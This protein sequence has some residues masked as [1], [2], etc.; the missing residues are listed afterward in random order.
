MSELWSAVVLTDKRCDDCGLRC[1]RVVEVVKEI[2]YEQSA[3][4]LCQAC[5]G[6]AVSHLFAAGRKLD[7]DL[8]FAR[9]VIWCTE[10]DHPVDS[11]CHDSEHECPTCKT[12]LRAYGGAS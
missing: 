7:S 12:G 10:C 9:L 3:I 2:V 1:E 5:L 8:T 4:R 6:K 11:A